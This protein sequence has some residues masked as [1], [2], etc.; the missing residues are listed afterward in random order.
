MRDRRHL[1]PYLLLLPP[2]LLFAVFFIWPLIT[3][4]VIS[5]YDYSRMTGMVEVFT[6]KNYQR[7]LLDEFYLAIVGH[8]LQLAA[9]TAVLTVVIGYPVALYLTVARPRARAAV[10]FFILSPL[11]I[12]VIVRSFG[13]VM[14]VGPKGLLETL[15]SAVGLPG[16]NILHT[17]AAVLLGLVN[18]LLPFVVLSIATALQ[19]ID[20]AVP[21]AASSLGASPWRNFLSVTLP[22]SLPGV[23]SGV[24]IAFSLAS[25]T[26]VTP[27]VLGG[28]QFKVLSTMLFQQAVV[29]QNWPF[30]AA[31][32]ITLV[33]I[34]LMAVTLQ[35]RLV[36]RGRY[37]AVFQ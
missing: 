14:I 19:A 2:A 21:L 29:L 16:G 27:A 30:G 11:M 33:L 23:L 20:P 12:S 28:S 36:E 22:L 4:T 1:V 13:W 6:L 34:V 8:T 18:V 15:L 7:I 10:I 5:F 35:F 37:K 25:S 9:T 24:L 26:F 31:L 17:E 32:A 3:L